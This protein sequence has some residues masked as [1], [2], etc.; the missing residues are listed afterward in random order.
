LPVANNFGAAEHFPPI[1]SHSAV[2]DDQQAL[3]MAAN[4]SAVAQSNFVGVG[5]TQPTMLLVAG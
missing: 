1:A 5:D 3:D 2:C 4:G